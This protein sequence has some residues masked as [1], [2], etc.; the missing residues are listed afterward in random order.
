MHG[1]CIKCGTLRECFLEGKRVVWIKMRTNLRR[2]PKL[3]ALATELHQSVEAMESLFSKGHSSRE[4]ALATA[5]MCGVTVTFDTVT[6]VTVASLLDLWGV[7]QEA[8]DA[9]NFVE[10][11]TLD[12]VDSITKIPGF[13]RAL[14]K[15]GWVEEL[16]NGLRFTN[17][18]EHN[19]PEKERSQPMSGAERT[20]RWRERRNGVTPVTNETKCDVERRGEDNN[21]PPNPPK[22]GRRQ[23]KGEDVPRLSREELQRQRIDL[24]MEEE[25]SGEAK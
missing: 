5:K 10:L 16:P 13:G 19:I 23:K 22:G 3:L 4:T 11:M 17:F 8:V 7:T 15:V 2:L 25:D 24:G 6:A 9:Q 18:G 20:R 14:A 1:D 21:T 12:Q